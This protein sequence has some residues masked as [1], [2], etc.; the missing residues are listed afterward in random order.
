MK[1]DFEKKT[2]LV[3]GGS[4]GIGKQIVQD[5]LSLGAKVLATST[6]FQKSYHPNLN[7]YCVDFKNDN[8]TKDFLEFISKLS[9]DVCINNAGINKIDSILE[10]DHNDW[11]SI[12]NVNLSAP[13]KIIQTVSKK[14]IEKG[15]G[16]IINV[17]SI[18]G[19]ISIAK[20]ASYSSSK[21]GLKGLTLASA[22]EL[23]KHNVLVNTVS[24]GFTLTDLTEKVLGEQKMKEISKLIP[25][26]RMAQPSEISKT[27]LF[28][29]SDLNTYISGQDIV[30]DGGFIN[31]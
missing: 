29:A 4:R 10:V 15:S 13:F 19:N 11:Q 28:L 21:F 18:W 16:K 8:N 31:V 6:S 17:S 1:L 27:V 22:A 9:F 5:F 26:K 30:I 24:P 3:T 25:I 7:F 14:M 23:A 12:L 20:R 2:V